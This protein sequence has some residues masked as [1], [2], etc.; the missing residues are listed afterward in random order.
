M[1]G[2]NSGATGSFQEGRGD[3][4]SEKGRKKGD[5]R[6]EGCLA[7]P[8]ENCRGRGDGKTIFNREWQ[9]ESRFNVAR[10]GWVIL[11]L[12]SEVKTAISGATR[13]SSKNV[14]GVIESGGG[15]WCH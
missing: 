3:V 4:K 5:G 12:G 1:I 15:G 6:L 9:S 8:W 2:V 13:D 14:G 7:L 10:R 11:R